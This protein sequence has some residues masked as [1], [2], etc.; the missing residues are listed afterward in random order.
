MVFFAVF[1]SSVAH[2][3]VLDDYVR[4][5]MRENR[6]PG[7][8]LAIVD[9]WR[10]ASVRCYGVVEPKTNRPVVPSTLF[11]AGSISKSVAAVG[12]LRL[13]EQGVLKLDEDVNVKLSGWK[14]PENSFTQ[15]QKVTLRRILSHTAGLTVHGFPGYPVNA[16]LPTLIQI[17][18]GENP[19]N[20]APIVVDTVPG[21]NWRYSGGGYTVM[22]ELVQEVTG[23]PYAGFLKR[24]V[25]DP[26]GMTDSSYEQP[27]P[28]SRT[29]RAATG[30]Y[31]NGSAVRG[32][33]HVY[34]EMAAAGL[35]TTPTDLATFILSI[36]NSYSGLPGGVLSQAT[37]R[38]ML[39][40]QKSGDGLGAF[41]EGS[42]QSLRFSHNGRD[43]GFDAFYIGCAL[44]GQGAAIMIN[45][46]ENSGVVDRI[47]KFIAAKYQ[48]P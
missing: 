8:S 23:E 44:K 29:Q 35:W 14:V 34:P 10:I 3:D 7:L 47:A 42:G 32:R 46:N 11:Q 41:L 39:T 21:D 28:L 1:A 16:P 40:V 2:A 30:T 13:V 18:N 26:A 20:T 48:W 17:L 24:M 33:W 22:Q 25:L 9:K 27:Q 36:E 31:P 19:A 6:V 43:E 15:R 12:T 4:E 37:A 38:L 45:A 5:Q